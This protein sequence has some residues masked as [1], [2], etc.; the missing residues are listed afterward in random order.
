[1]DRFGQILYDLG[2][3]IGLDL[4]P[5]EHRICQ[6]NYKDLFSIQLHYDEA[7][8]QVLIATFLCEVPAGKFREK[9][10]IASLK[11]N[12][13]YPR[14]GTLAYSE[15]NNQLTLFDYVSSKSLKPNELFSRLEP[16]IDKA[17]AWKEAVEKGKPL[18]EEESSAPPKGSI[19]GL[20]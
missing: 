15:R 11:S 17:K 2:K 3:E 14:I 6:L 19:F 16:F 10:L 20:K 18:P 9:L 13:A 4:Y 12:H 1:M 5:D 8:E 7:K